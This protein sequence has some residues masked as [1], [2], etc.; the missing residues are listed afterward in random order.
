MRAEF[1]LEI[2]QSTWETHTEKQLPKK[3]VIMYW[4]LKFLIASEKLQPEDLRQTFGK[5]HIYGF[6]SHVISVHLE[7]NS[8]FSFSSWPVGLKAQGSFSPQETKVGSQD[9]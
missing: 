2:S 5:L 9:S 8:Y 3:N 6:Y 7:I 4:W 1:L